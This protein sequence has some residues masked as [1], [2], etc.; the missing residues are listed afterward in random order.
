MVVV[1]SCYDAAHS[2]AVKLIRIERRMNAAKDRE[3]LEEI[4]LQSA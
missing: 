3:V 4:L 1:A 2:E